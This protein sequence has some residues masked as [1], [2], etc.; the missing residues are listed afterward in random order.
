MIKIQ[1][2]RTN[3]FVNQKQI[4]NYTIIVSL[5]LAS[6]VSYYHKSCSKLWRHFR[7][8]SFIIQAT[9]FTW[10]FFKFQYSMLVG[11]KKILESSKKKLKVS[12]IFTICRGRTKAKWDMKSP[13][14]GPW[15]RHQKSQKFE[16]TLFGS[17]YRSLI[18]CSLLDN[19]QNYGLN[20]CIFLSMVM[21]SRRYRVGPPRP[22]GLLLTS[23]SHS[24][25]AR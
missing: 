19:I 10:Y 17:S 13:E 11:K 2:N 9:G 23:L 25:K 1:L 21:E 16:P 18:L 4:Y 7:R 6:V 22:R 14:C 8:N 20:I 24:P 5:A 3:G 12:W 15:P